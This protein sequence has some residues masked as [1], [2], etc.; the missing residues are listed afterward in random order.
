MK[1]M[2]IKQQLNDK[3]HLTKITIAF[4]N[5]HI[6]KIISSVNDLRV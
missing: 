4:N 3:K 5:I 1:K 2:V 6:A